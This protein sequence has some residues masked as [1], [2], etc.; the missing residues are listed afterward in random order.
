MVCTSE[1]I[2][3]EPAQ[4]ACQPYKPVRHLLGEQAKT[5]GEFVKGELKTA[6]Y[7][8]NATNSKY[9]GTGAGNDEKNRF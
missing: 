4:S 9:K 8:F 7:N 2:G 1:F 6:R 3:I 5:K